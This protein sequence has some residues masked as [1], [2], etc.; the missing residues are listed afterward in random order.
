MLFTYNSREDVL[1]DLKIITFLSKCIWHM[2]VIFFFLGICA[3]MFC[4]NFMNLALSF[5][6][7]V[8]FGA[9]YIFFVCGIYAETLKRGLRQ[10]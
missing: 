3:A 4:N 5:L 2:S 1:V 7:A 6:G 8:S 9:S 10:L